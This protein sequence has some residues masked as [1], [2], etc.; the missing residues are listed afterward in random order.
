MEEEIDNIDWNEEEEEYEYDPNDPNTKKKKKIK[1]ELNDQEIAKIKSAINEMQNNQVQP[2]IT[3]GRLFNKPGFVSKPEKIIFKDF[4]IGKKMS[5]TIQIINISYN[6][7]SFHLQPLD[8]DVIDF[9]DI[10]YQPCGRIPAGISTKMTLHFTPLVNKDYHSK[11]KLL[12]ETGL[13]EIP[14][15]CLCQK[16][17]ISFEN[18][19]ID[20]GEVILGQNVTIP[21]KV[22]NDGILPC[23]YTILN[24]NKEILN[25]VDE[26]EEK[27]ENI[28]LDSSYK[29]YIERNIILHKMDYQND[30]EK[31]GDGIFEEI[32]EKKVNEFKEKILKEEK[33]LYEKEE[34][35]KKEKEEA[36]K[37]A[38]PKDKKAKPAANKQKAK[39][40][41]PEIELIEGLP[42]ERYDECMKKIEEFKENF[43]LKDQNDIDEFNKLEEQ[44]KENK[45]KHYMLKQLKYSIHGNFTGYSKKNVNI[46]LNALYIGSFHIKCYLRIDYKNHQSEFKEFS[47]SF[48]VVDLPIFSDKKIY[49]FNYI[50]QDQIFREKVSLINKSN[51]PYKLQVFFHQDLNDFIE[52]N[53]SLGFVQANSKFDIW[54]KL[55]V[56]KSAYK[57]INFFRRKSEQNNEFN[58][59]LKIVLNNV[60]IP[61]IINL[62]F[63][64]TIDLIEISEKM[65]N[66]GK[67]FI[68]ESTK[69]TVSLQNK[70]ALPMKYGFIMLPKEFTVKTN[71]DNL[72]SNEKTFV[73]IIYEAKD[74]FTGH[75]EGDIFC[76]VINDELT[77]QNIK[78]K[79]HIEL[80]NPEIKITPKKIQFQSLP[81]DESEEFRLLITNKNEY[82][83]FD[84]EFLT[85]PYCISGLIIQPKVFTLQ[86]KGYTTCVIRYDSKM[87][88]YDAFT[89]EEIERE[90]G[91]KL[92]DGFEQEE[93]I[94]E[95]EGNENAKLQEKVKNEVDNVL[96]AANENEQGKKKKDDKKKV[97]EKKDD[98]KKP[99]V[100]KDKKALEEEEKKKKEEEEAKLKE[101]EEKKEQRLKT[102]NKEEELKHFGA[103]HI[104]KDIEND[105]SS[106]W[107]FL[108]PMFYRNHIDEDSIEIKS[109]EIKLKTNFVEVHTTT[110]EKILIFN[111]TEI[112]FNEVSVKTRKTI[113]VII[114]N[115]SNKIQKLK[116][117]P[118]ILT[119]CFR[120]VNAIRDLPPHSSFNYIV[121]FIP[122]LDIPYFD[123][124]TVYTEETQS[125]VHLK[126]IGVRPEITTNIKDG[127]FFIGNC[128]INN[129]IE[130]TFDIIN[131]SD[132]KIN[133][134]IKSLK[135]GKKNKTGLK[136]FC[137][138]PFCGEINN[139]D[140]VTIKVSFNGDH[141]DF[142]NFFDFVLLDVPNQKVENKILVCAFCWERQVYWKEFAEIKFPQKEENFVNQ[143]IE[144]DIFIDA[145][146]LKSNA[147]GSN[148]D[149]IILIFTPENQVQIENK[150]NSMNSTQTKLTKTKNKKN[151]KKKEEKNNENNINEPIIT[152][153][154]EKCFKR[155]LTI[156]NCKLD[157]PKNEKNGNYEVFLDKDC[158]YFTC[159]NPK[160]TVNSGQEIVITF[161]Y[162]K[163]S[164]DPLIK[165]VECLKGVG[166]WV[167]SKVEL[168]I[169]GGFIQQNMNDNV[170]VNIILKAYVEQI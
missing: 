40:K 83:S 143:I 68:D 41:E 18:E 121:E 37:A 16:C 109:T 145:L 22:K 149:N 103:K 8:D 105:R 20:F 17:L 11:L 67:R 122:E 147:I 78:I 15:E 86:P 38:N 54:V 57:L 114:T 66:Y 167:E 28:D 127:V 119:N 2:Q 23:R 130:K 124:F 120:I 35:E 81:E 27:D 99:D 95:L 13:C 92:E 65:I 131:K 29:D 33:E 117:K 73:D 123:D 7:N 48:N 126:G 39:E 25:M 10:D 159:D 141:Q 45:M 164:A 157:D 36:E 59:P 156:G 133:F 128:V 75:R 71:I 21:L 51:M 64:L 63:W 138:V 56:G 168:K 14:I 155:K 170:S 94:K 82:K 91:I 136:P 112:D 3:G 100:K 108:I 106:H 58:F 90:L 62:H 70:S 134:E 135:E 107:E 72:L 1:K 132:F 153:E 104:F 139:K 161:G 6:Y 52:L 42:K 88:N 24:E 118:L 69:V 142:L 158:P 166:M 80:V 12:S 125:T 53:P 50:I 47:I 148:N 4:E 77:T 97:V 74:N 163:P 101:I 160:G 26:E 31:S 162:K 111:K 110:V 5:Q 46:T 102:F 98:K 49:E 79:Y 96:N 55:K 154:N 84:C 129:T 9:I 151:N 60:N 140:K 165:E 93:K 169:N 32:R 152:E 137:Y 115:K 76:R 146:K 30:R 85:P 116:M 43:Q 34:Q 89:Y 44:I 19:N 150:P 61:I 113:N 144:Q 87:R